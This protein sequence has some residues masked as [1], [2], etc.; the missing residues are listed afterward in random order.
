MG[1]KARSVAKGAMPVEVTLG[2]R[3]T[4]ERSLAW[5]ALW[6]LLLAAP[7]DEVLAEI[8]QDRNPGRGN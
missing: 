8:A 6:L 3:S 4:D 7:R 1:R 5:E 2:L